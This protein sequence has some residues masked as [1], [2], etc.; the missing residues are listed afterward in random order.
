M[1]GD[2]RTFLKPRDMLLSSSPEMGYHESASLLHVSI[3]QIVIKVNCRKPV[4]PDISEQPFK[5]NGI[6][7]WDFMGT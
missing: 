7:R 6:H 3:S 5:Y 2:G 1:A 4:L